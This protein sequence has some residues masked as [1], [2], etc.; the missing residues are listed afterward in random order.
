MKE[1][2]NKKQ[3]YYIDTNIALDYVTGRNP[4]TIFILNSLIEVGSIMVSSSFLAM[5]AADFQKESLYFIEKVVVKKWELR[6]A[7]RES[8][9]KDLARGDFYKVQDWIEELRDELKLQLYDFLIDSYTW[10]IAQYISQSSNLFAPDVI[11]LSSSIFAALSGIA[12]AKGTKLPCNIFISNDDF[13]KKEAKKV[14]RELE[15]SYPEIL[16]V[17]EMK[18][19]FLKASSKATQ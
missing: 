12:T 1:P 15:I 5:E 11:H 18:N 17:S 13:L 6:K 4:E 10:E 16:T 8:Y 7:V 3:A 19:K 14:K 9:R 2:T